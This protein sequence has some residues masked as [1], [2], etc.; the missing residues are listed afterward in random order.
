LRHP[1]R[2]IA[3]DISGGIAVGDDVHQFVMDF[4]MVFL[5]VEELLLRQAIQRPIASPRIRKVERPAFIA[6]VLAEDREMIR[7][8][9]LPVITRFLGRTPR[10]EIGLPLCHV[11]WIVI[12]LA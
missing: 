4:Q 10:R 3:G 2:P 5:D 9:F 6:L 11:G 7:R 8:E 12:G 1:K